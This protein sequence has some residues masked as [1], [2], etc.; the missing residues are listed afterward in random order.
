MSIFRMK[1]QFKQSTTCW[2]S[3]VQNMLNG[4]NQV[5]KAGIKSGFE[6]ITDTVE[7]TQRLVFF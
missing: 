2:T 7:Q 4:V 6:S 5:I 1:L 3:M